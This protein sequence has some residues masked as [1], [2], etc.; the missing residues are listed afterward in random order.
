MSLV[1]VIS[2]CHQCMSLEYVIS[3]NFLS[4]FCSSLRS[5]LWQSWTKSQALYPLLTVEVI[6]NVKDNYIHNLL[7]DGDEHN[8]HEVYQ[9]LKTGPQ[10]LVLKVENSLKLTH[11]EEQG[12]PPYTIVACK[13]YYKNTDDSRFTRNMHRYISGPV[14]DFMFLKFFLNSLNLLMCTDLM[15]LRFLLIMKPKKRCSV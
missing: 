5:R 14:D 8:I 6:T 13:N 10:E 4:F 7:E 12:I 2:V 9:Q 15:S 11:P 1:Y 3:N